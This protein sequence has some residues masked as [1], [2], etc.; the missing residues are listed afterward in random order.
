MLR[1]TI[2]SLLVT[3]LSAVVA[4]ANISEKPVS[5]VLYGAA[6]GYQESPV[7][8][9]DGENFL[10]AWHDERAWPSVMY[11]A[12]VNRQGELLD[13]TGIRIPAYGSPGAVVFAGDTYVVLWI[14]DATPNL[15]GARISREGQLV[16]GPRVLVTNVPND[17]FQAASN[18]SRI[19]IAWRD[20]YYVLSAQG[21]PL[22]RDVPLPIAPSVRPHVV[23]NGSG[24]LLAW[25][26][27]ALQTLL[28]DSRGQ[29]T[30]SINTIVNYSGYDLSIASDG[31]D[32]LVLYWSFTTQSIESRI[33]SGDG[34]S[35]GPAFAVAAMHFGDERAP[36]AWGGNNYVALFRS[37]EGAQFPNQDVIKR[38]RLERQGRP[39]DNAKIAVA[40]TSENGATPA[41]AS[42]GD[43]VLVG[44][45]A[46][47]PEGNLDDVYAIKASSVADPS[48]TGMLVSRSAI[49]QGAPSI[50][51]SGR[52]YLVV[53]Q[54][55][56]ALY[57]NR[58]LSN[59]EHL[60]GTGAFVT[61]F[62]ASNA[63]PRVIFDGENYVL[64]W[65]GSGAING[66]GPVLRLARVQPDSGTVLD[67]LGVVV[68]DTAGL[69][70]FDIA[71]DGQTLAV[72]WSD[73]RIHAAR[74]NRTLQALDVRHDLSPKE[75]SA[76]NPAA[77]W[78]GTEWL[79]AFE[80]QFFC[81]LCFG[82]GRNF[83]RANLHAVRLSPLFN[84]LDPQPIDIAVTDSESNVGAH[85]ASDGNEFA[86]VWTGGPLGQ[87]YLRAR[88][89][90]NSS[91]LDD[92]ATLAS[93]TASS[94][95]WDGSQYSV[96]Y[97]S[98]RPDGRS[99]ALLTHLGR[100]D[101]PLPRDQMIISATPDDETSPQL[102]ATSDGRVTATYLRVASE[103]LYGGVARAFL[104]EPAPARTRPSRAR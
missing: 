28:L 32:Y 11:A 59:G 60:D 4:P 99:D 14:A 39:L 96:A 31:R 98:K 2:L 102:V 13:P 24:F 85:I 48:S 29:P 10:L 95:V 30:G 93:G 27:P 80:E 16:D 94:A 76:G 12:R 91:L 43:D 6:P 65:I 45:R 20:R 56:S 41:V 81:S 23:S 46:A 87:N 67:V 82:P 77:A 73:G 88:H 9:S 47:R 104:R 33:V 92:V 50:A 7:I 101:A 38:V 19:V 8:A 5:D 75:M 22:Q 37:P 53:R 35:V 63:A 57:F 72:V 3:I 83:I 51:F 89:M 25:P 84:L 64:A 36:L 79:I 34:I 18:G 52:N 90:K 68:G 100:A 17:A 86:I 40:S 71:T 78:N 97:E 1:R 62:L 21:E 26:K 103:P 66:V 49:P 44:W 70:S 15:Y 69:S 58:V 54:E 55:R 42:N 74:F 61:Q